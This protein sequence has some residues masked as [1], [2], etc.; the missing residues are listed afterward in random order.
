MAR[1][2]YQTLIFRCLHAS[3]G[4]LAAAGMITGYWIY[5]T[6]D[7]R[8]SH[9]PFPRATEA[10]VELHEE[11]GGLFVSL[12]ILFIGYSL[13]AGRRRLV[14]AKSLQQLGKISHPIG[15]YS[16]HRFVNTG[17][18]VMGLLI[19]VSGDAL[20]DDVLEQ[21]A[22]T[23]LAYTLHL[24]AWA[25]MV[26]LTVAHVGLSLKVGDMPFSVCGEYAGAYQRLPQPLAPALFHLGT[27]SLEQISTQV[28]SLAE[29]LSFGC[30]LEIVNLR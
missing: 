18:L 23:D 14:Q 9:I 5:N 12:C 24:V 20:S 16:L 15:W 25:G 22:L 1:Q 13:F 19:I 30:H 8:F 7:Q 10:I 4:L 17:L 2:P 26:L 29:F 3:Q 28:L 11:I 6:W 21:G 27:S